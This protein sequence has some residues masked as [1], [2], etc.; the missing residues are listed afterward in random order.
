V[1]ECAAL[2][3]LRPPDAA[4]EPDRVD[5]AVFRDD[6]PELTR[7]E[8][9]ACKAEIAQ[10]GS[11]G[12]RA[13]LWRLAFG[14]S[15]APELYAVDQVGQ[16]VRAEAPEFAVFDGPQGT[17]T[18]NCPAELMLMTPPQLHMHLEVLSRAGMFLINT[19]AAP[20]VQGAAMTGMHGIGVSTP[21]AAVVAA[22]TVGL[23]GVLHIPNGGM[24][25]IGLLSMMV[26]AGAPAVT[27]LTGR[28]L[29]VDGANPNVHCSI[30]PVV[31]SWAIGHLL[32][33]ILLPAKSRSNHGI[34][35]AATVRFG[36]APPP[37]RH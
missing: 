36:A 26:A 4:M 22:A 35:R 25:T 31:T 3:A 37:D 32:G 14:E 10:G 6:G 16:P 12:Q 9:A 18:V 21:S 13:L 17:L 8:V 20:G 5:R 1:L 19:V 34:S 33:P 29:S 30:A 15:A 11:V 2:D 27:R 24:F 23:L 7:R 28:T